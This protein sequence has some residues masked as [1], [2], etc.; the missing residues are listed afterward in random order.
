MV[1][2]Q[3][4]GNF[5]IKALQ[6]ELIEQGH[7][8]TG[9]LVNSFEQRALSLPNSLVLEILMD[10]YGTYV[11]NGRQKGGKKVPIDVLVAWIE[12]KAI[13]SGDKKVKSLAFA[14]QQTI[15]K[16]GS[17]TKGSFRF[18][19]NGRRKGFIDFVI[20]EELNDIYNE[21]EEQVFKGYD[22]AIATIVNDFNSKA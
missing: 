12:R 5:I 21:L 1:D 6:M 19:N 4:V 16:E 14:I 3:K 22:A 10:D 8:A 20:S 13:V 15:H 2:F 9:N 18:S 7:K 17:P 11:N